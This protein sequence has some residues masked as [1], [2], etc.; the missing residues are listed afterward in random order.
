[1]E[2]FNDVYLNLTMKTVFML[3]WVSKSCQDAKF[4]LKV[5]DDVFVNTEMVWST[6]ESSHLYSA[7][8]TTKDGV[9]P[10]GAA[11]SGNVDYAVIGHVM[12]TVP[13]RDPASKWY[14]PV[15]FYPLNIFPAF[16]SGTAYIF[17]GSL[18]PALYKCALNTPFINLEDVFLTGLC[19]STQ[20]R[21][22]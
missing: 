3:K 22:R 14:L 19:A 12:H 5:D 1:M 2:D 7:L 11:T 8:L 6:L 21:L 17:T 18:V 16:T 4:V 13:I 9:Q 15:S 20:L 10:D